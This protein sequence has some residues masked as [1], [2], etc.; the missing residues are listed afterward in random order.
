MKADLTLSGLAVLARDSDLPVKSE[1]VSREA[2]HFTMV[3][4]AADT[5]TWATIDPGGNSTLRGNMFS[6]YGED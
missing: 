6:G 1:R 5:G 2:A 3:N 4:T